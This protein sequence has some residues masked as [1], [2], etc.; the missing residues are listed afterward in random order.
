MYMG[1]KQYNKFDQTNDFNVKLNGFR[2]IGTYDKK[3]IFTGKVYNG[4][5][6]VFDG[7]IQL[8]KGRENGKLLEGEAINLS[9]GIGE[10]K[11]IYNGT[12]SKYKFILGT[13]RRPYDNTIRYIR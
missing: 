9:V 8:Y 1:N 10:D 4:K 5:K 12:F 3:N 11:K 6:L 7:T 2:Y 13:I